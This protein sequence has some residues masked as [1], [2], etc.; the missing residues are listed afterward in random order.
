MRDKAAHG[1]GTQHLRF[2]KVFLE[3]QSNDG[4]AATQP[5]YS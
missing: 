2:E 4:T 3:L 5:A 1:W